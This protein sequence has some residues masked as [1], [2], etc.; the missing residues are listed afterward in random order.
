MYQSIEYNLM[1]FYSIYTC[2]SFATQ[3]CQNRGSI[4]S[5]TTTQL[6]YGWLVN[7]NPFRAV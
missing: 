4:L 7:L 2:I 3:E 6:L 5:S 1:L